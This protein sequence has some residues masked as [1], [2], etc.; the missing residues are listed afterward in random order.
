MEGLGW[1]FGGNWVDFG[2]IWEAFWGHFGDFFRVRWIFENVCFTKVKP[3]FLRSGM[4]LVRY[5]FVLCFWI[6]TLGVF[7]VESQG[8]VGP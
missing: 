4:V 5:F 1:T 2:V 6:D 7:V 3:Y 8:F